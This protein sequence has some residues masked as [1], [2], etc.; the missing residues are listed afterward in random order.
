MVQGVLWGD[1]MRPACRQKL[2]NGLRVVGNVVTVIILVPCNCRSRII[3]TLGKTL[4]KCLGARFGND[5]Y[6]MSSKGQLC[7]SL[8]SVHDL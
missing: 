4:A 2:M 6:Y 3:C 1:R 8:P 7:S 5:P